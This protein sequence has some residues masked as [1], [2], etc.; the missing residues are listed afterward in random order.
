LKIHVESGL[1]D[2]LLRAKLL[3]FDAHGNALFDEDGGLWVRDGKVAGSGSFA[4]VRAQA[5]AQID[6]QHWPQ[7]LIAPGFVDMHVHCVQTDVIGSRADGLLPWLEK[8][9]FPHEAKFTNEAYAQEVANFFCDELLRHGVTTALA[10]SSS[11]PQSVNALFEAAQPRH[12]R[13]ITG[14]CLMDRN[15][16]DGVRDE[17]ERSLFD[18]EALIQRWHG[19]ARLGYAITP[20]FAASCSQAQLRGAGE[21]AAKYPDVWIQSHVSENLDEMAWIAKLFPNDKSY[22]GVYERFGL[23]RK[24]SVYAHGIH[25]NDVDRALLKQHQT[26]IACSPTSNAFLGS[27]NFDYAA[28]ADQGV[29]HGLAS[30]VG[31]GM[32]FSPFAT[33]RAAYVSARSDA[34]IG[35]DAVT[36]LA[37]TA[38]QGQSLS[39]ARLWWLHTA[40]A[41]LAMG[42]SHQATLQVGDD[43]DFVLIDPNATPLLSRKT[44]QSDELNQWLFALIMLADD[45]AITRTHVQG[46]LHKNQALAQRIH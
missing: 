26:A 33:M 4:A 10:F 27:G 36:G 19:K 46:D 2:Q 15:C 23:L 21:L 29:L 43:A 6:V 38:K 40:G 11:H 35:A 34:R 20:R 7:H 44:G 9:T 32:S 1:S 17:T 28:A 8:Y 5:P 13:V 16:P 18:T 39:A 24:R 14:K 42:L 22:L 3:R 41:A 31:G 25:L 37:S 45:R 12:M 30:D